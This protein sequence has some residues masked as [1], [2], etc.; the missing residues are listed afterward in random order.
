MTGD[1]Q[2][3]PSA[4]AAAEEAFARLADLARTAL[5]TQ[6][7]LARQ[8]VDL[9]KAT[10]SGELDRNSAAK[11]YLEAATRESAR[12]WRVAGELAVDYATDLVALG[13]RSS[14]TVLRETTA[15]GGKDARPANGAASGSTQSTFSRT[16]D[17]SSPTVTEHAVGGRRVQVSLRGS[18]GGCAEGTIMVANQHPRPRRI[19]LSAGDVSDSMG[20]AS[21]ATLEVTPARVTVPS[22][23]ERSISLGVDLDSASLSAGKR[24]SSTV[25]VTG[26]DEATIEVTI[27]IST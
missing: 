4:A 24:Y 14:T 9:A 11:A 3:T 18:L 12:Y 21:A 17:D 13:D 5:K 6:V 20:V 1:S 2:P 26:G 16:S 22:G 25:D 7:S 19:E 23:Q 15:A 10:L 27:D 8:S